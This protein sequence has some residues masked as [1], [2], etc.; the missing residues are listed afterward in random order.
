MLEKM[1]RVD[2]VIDENARVNFRF[3]FSTQPGRHI[4]HLDEVTKNYGEKKILTHTTARLERGD[5]VALIGANGRGKSTL[6]RIIAGTEPTTKGERRLGHNVSF[7]FY[8]QHQLGVA[9]RG[10][11]FMLDELKSGQSVQIRRQNC[12]RC[13]GLLSVLGRRRFQENQSAVRRRKIAGGFGQSA[14]FAGQLP[15]TWMNRPTTWT[16]SR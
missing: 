12:G 15:A 8:A 10:R 16:C 13:T 14:A 9:E 11:Q 1:D 2:A 4:L 3:N 5:H 7:S 6:L